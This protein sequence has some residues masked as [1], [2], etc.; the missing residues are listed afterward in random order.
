MNKNVVIFIVVVLILISSIWGSI[1]DGK[2]EDLDKRLNE[3]LVQLQ[4][5][6]E[7]SSKQRQA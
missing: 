5:V 2:R 7:Q 3:T 4:E 1:V 6:T